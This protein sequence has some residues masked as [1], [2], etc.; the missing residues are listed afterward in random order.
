MLHSEFEVGDMCLTETSIFKSSIYANR[1][2]S[3]KYTSLYK[4]MLEDHSQYE[5]FVDSIRSISKYHYLSSP[6]CSIYR[7]LGGKIPLR[8]WKLLGGKKVVQQFFL[9]AHQARNSDRLV[10]K[11][12]SHLHYLDRVIEA[13]PRSK[14]II[15]IRHPV[16]VFSSHKRRHESTNEGWLDL[17]PYSFSQRYLRDFKD[18]KKYSLKYDQTLLVKYEN[19]TSYPEEIFQKICS[20]VG[21][22]FEIPPIKGECKELSGWDPDPYLSRPITPITKNWNEYLGIDEAKQ[23]EETLAEEISEVGYSRKT[24]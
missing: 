20:F 9:H 24:K 13:Y 11:T 15:M 8:I 6:A 2:S 17:T 22:D 23:V 21:V 14:I 1:I 12:P 7:R 4:Y 5:R 3:G 10:E 18:I 19:F 16:E